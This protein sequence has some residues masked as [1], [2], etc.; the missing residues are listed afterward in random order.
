MSALAADHMD[1]AAWR[2]AAAALALAGATA[3]ILMRDALSSMVGT[4]WNSVT[5]NHILLVPAIL[6]W[7]VWQRRGVLAA[8]RPRPWAPGLIG[9]AAAG[10]VWFLGRIGDVNVVQQFGLVFTLQALVLTLLGPLVARVL[11]FP[12]GFMLF[13]V[14]FGEGLIPPLQ[15]VTAHFIVKGLQLLNI[16]V[17]LD[18]Y[19]LMTPSGNF[20]VAEACSGVRYLISTLV[21]GI[22]F[23]NVAFKS[24]WRR[25]VIIALS[26]IIPI[27]ANGLRA[28]GIVYI[29][30]LTD[31][32]YATGVDHLIYG[33]IF[34]AFVTIFLLIV[35][36]SFSDKPAGAPAVDTATLPPQPALPARGSAALGIGLAA[37]ALVGAGPAYAALIAARQPMAQVETFAAL[38]PPAGWQAVPAPDDWAPRYAGVDAE[39]LEHFG[40]GG[41]T[42]SLYRGRYNKQTPEGELIGY[43][44]SA[45]APL[46]RWVRVAARARTVDW[47]GVPTPVIA[48]QINQG[49]AMVRDAWQVYWVND[50]L[51]AND[52]AAKAHG[53]LAKAFGGSLAAGTVVISVP[54]RFHGIGAQEE[55]AAFAAA[56]PPVAALLSPPQAMDEGGK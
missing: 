55:L 27:I 52:L 11:V 16:P 9:V 54:R 21:L 37:L 49:N 20:E 42:L 3:L 44:N 43:G 29:A 50:R 26:I 36:M 45:A 24:P 51:L 40:K 28:L 39:R 17:Y 7:L 56:L 34:F 19:F 13:L 12:L 38:P 4:W 48:M 1:K 47:G 8:V 30:Y 25:A 53:A 6:A 32:E 23:A 18:G 5:F 41:A 2:A 15:D 35:G 31:N 10:G 33:W 22:L 14:P 46:E